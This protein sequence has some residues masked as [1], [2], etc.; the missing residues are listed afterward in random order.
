LL[1]I[2]LVNLN[3]RIGVHMNFA[4]S[5]I[6]ALVCS[7]QS[8]CGCHQARSCGRQRGNATPNFNVFRLIKYLKYKPKKYFSAN[9]RNC[10]EEPILLQLLVEH[11]LVYDLL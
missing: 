1:K 11:K 4:Q 6:P 10:L 3:F 2:V 5:S 7:L 9:Q 8:E